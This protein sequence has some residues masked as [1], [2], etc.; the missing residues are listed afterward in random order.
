MAYPYEGWL[1]RNVEYE[2]FKTKKKT[3]CSRRCR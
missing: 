3:S 2:T 1:V